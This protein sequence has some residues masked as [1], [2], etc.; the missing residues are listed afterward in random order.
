[1]AA[2]THVDNSIADPVNFIHNN[3]MSTVHIL[4]FARELKSLKI[5]YSCS[6]SHSLS[7]NHPMV[8]I[9]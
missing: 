5:F 7:F 6:H 4:E 9:A 3:V 8:K 1:M 2:E